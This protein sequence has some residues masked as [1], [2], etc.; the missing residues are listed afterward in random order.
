LGY[1]KIRLD[2]KPNVTLTMS[3]ENVSIFKYDETT[4]TKLVNT[5]INFFSK[6]ELKISHHLK[7]QK[8]V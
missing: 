7:I 4:E 2:K 5:S 6:H 3:F 8:S 1:I